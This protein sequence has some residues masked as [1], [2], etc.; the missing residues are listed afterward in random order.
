MLE[1]AQ[2]SNQAGEKVIKKERIGKFE[3]EQGES[4]KWKCPVCGNFVFDEPSDWDYCPI[5]DAL[6]AHVYFSGTTKLGQKMNFD[7]ARKAWFCKD[8]QSGNP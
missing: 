4:G 1:M 6:N 3:F 2:N 8:R 7:E 5:C